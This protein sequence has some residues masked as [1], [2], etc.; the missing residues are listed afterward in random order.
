MSD[1]DKTLK[2]DNNAD[3]GT[4]V[5]SVID[6]YLNPALGGHGGFVNLV[7]VEGTKVFLELGGGCQGCAGAR[8]TMRAGVT[9]VIME[10]VP[11]VTEVVDAT[12]HG[13]GGNPY[14]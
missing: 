5:Q 11:D 3:L 12:D 10:H 14:Y 8:A 1:K 2:L 13:A 9:A 4:R 7:K 6:N